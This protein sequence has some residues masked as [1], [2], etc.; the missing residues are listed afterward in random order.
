[1]G[2]PDRWNTCSRTIPIEGEPSAFAYWEDSI[3]IGLESNRVVLLDA[4]TGTKKS[5]LSGHADM[6]LSLEF[7]LNG[8]LL[9]SGSEDKA[10]KLWDVQTGGVIK[11]F[12]DKDHT[13][14]I[15]AVSISPDRNTIASGTQDGTVRLWD[16]RTGTR[17]LVTGRH[18]DLVTAT[19][20]SPTNPRRLVST[21][22]DG[23]VQQWDLDGQEFGSR[24][25]EATSVFHVVYTPDGTRFAS[26]GGTVVTVRDSES[27][28]LVV[29][30]DAPSKRAV[31]K[32]GCFSLDGRFVACAAADTIYVWDIA[33]PSARLV[34][35]LTGHSKSIISL[36]FS[37]SLI[38]LSLDQSVKFWQS[39]SFL[40]DSV[41]VDNT[42]TQLESASVESVHLFPKDN[43][44][45]TTE[46]SGSV[47]TWTLATGTRSATF[48]TLAQGVRDVY[49]AGDALVIVWRTKEDEGYQVWDVR[50]RE[51]RTVES[52]LHKL[53]DLKIS[54]DGTKIFGLDNEH[55]EA[56]CLQSGEDA[57]LVKHQSS[58]P[59]RD[60]LA[61]RDSKVWLE[62]TKDVGWDFGGKRVSTFSLSDEFPDRPRLDI[63]ESTRV[64][65]TEAW[66]RDTVTGRP[67]FHIP[68]RYIKTAMK[69]QWDGRYLIYWSPSGEV[70]IMDFEC[71]CSSPR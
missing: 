12:K 67:V 57:G 64:G 58:D 41:T 36:A 19:S 33:G 59:W 11:T 28:A 43:M 66:V 39:S 46:S 40:T 17:R 31:L 53:L 34:G 50:K 56:R 65:A 9:V 35:N 6:I 62:S 70:V 5:I 16:I 2:L 44:A 68:E 63:T 55:I 60:A 69:R 4:I 61:V 30:L 14:A 51:F 52:S 8:S 42:S 20:F 27:G 7:S 48:P 26:C 25:H 54:R 18:G 47:K 13:S 38:S 22:M 49:L 45:V 32:Y 23:T 3:A 1:M 24:H 71:V 21:S 37:S 15:L 10:V 29:K